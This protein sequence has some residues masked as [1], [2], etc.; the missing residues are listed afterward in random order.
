VGAD[1]APWFPHLSPQVFIMLGMVGYFVG[2]VQTPLTGFIIVMEMTNDHS[3]LLPLMA[4]SFIAFG[5]SRLVCKKP[6]YVALARAFLAPPVAGTGV[7][8]EPVE[9][10]TS[11]KS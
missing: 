8:A 6:I 7:T 3:L 2:V 5:V 11:E 9:E 1:L 10:P 4:T